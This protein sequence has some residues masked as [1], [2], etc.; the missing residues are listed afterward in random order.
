ML[1]FAGPTVNSALPFPFCSHP[2]FCL[3]KGYVALKSF[4]AASRSR[5]PFAAIAPCPYVLPVVMAFKRYSI[6]AQR[7]FSGFLPMHFCR[8]FASAKHRI[9][10]V[11]CVSRRLQ[12]SLFNSPIVFIVSCGVTSYLRFVFLIWLWLMCLAL[13]NE[14]WEQR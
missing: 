6:R 11:C 10:A 7:L 8:L 12:R 2:S 13:R 9:L 5:T 4:P 1:A 3:G 14:V